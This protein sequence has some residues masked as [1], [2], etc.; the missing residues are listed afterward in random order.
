MNQSRVVYDSQNPDILTSIHKRTDGKK[1]VVLTF[2]DGPSKVLPE[3]LDVLHQT[4]TPAVFF[5]QSRLLY[6]ARPWQRLL[7]DGHQIGTHSVNHK[8]LTHKMNHQQQFE[9]LKCSVEAIHRVTGVTV[10]FFRPP[11][12]QFNDVTLQA[13][14]QLNLETVLWRIASMDWELKDNPDRIIANIVDNLEDGAI[15]LLHELSHTVKILPDLITAIK[16]QG[17]EFALLETE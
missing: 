10:R 9:E 12:G 8:N 6:P 14:K 15:I 3:L 1:T 13:A 17:Y 11:Y 4:A 7:A 2:D 5:W 16:K